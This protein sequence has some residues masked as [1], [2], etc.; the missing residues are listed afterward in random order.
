MA[1]Q[2][3]E[4]RATP[5]NYS[6]EAIQKATGKTWA[7]W[8]AILD[9]AGARNMTHREITHWLYEQGYTE[10]MWGQC[11]AI[12]YEQAMGR[13]EVGQDCYGQYFAT[14]RRIFDG[15]LDSVLERWV[16][17]TA[18]M[19]TFGTASLAAPPK[20]SATAK[21]RY[22]R[23]SLDDGSKVNVNISHTSGGRVLLQIDHRNVGNKAA[24]DAWKAYWKELLG[25]L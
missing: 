25:T 3:T 12:G 10:S 18:S 20:T 1:Q 22:W 8:F 11:V 17:G 24:V 19:T 9:A 23:A 6:D 15:T 16:A 13:R 2:L 14:G 7:E 4:A 21:W 5:Q